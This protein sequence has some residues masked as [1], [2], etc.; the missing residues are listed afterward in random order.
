[1]LSPQQIKKLYAKALAA[2][3]AG[4]LSDAEKSYAKILK[5]RPNVAEVQ[6]NMGRLRTQQGRL[7]EAAAHFE[8]A[9]KL[10]PGQAEIWLAYLKMAA[11][12]PNPQNLGK[13]L[14]RVGSAL[15]QFAEISFYRGLVAAGQGED[16]AALAAFEDAE[17]R[18]LQSAHLQ[19][20]LGRLHAGQGRV[21]EGLTAY[22]AA[23][24][25]EP[26]ND[27]ALAQKADLLRNIGEYDAALDAARAAIEVAP[28]AGQLYYSYA[29]IKK[30]SVGDPMIER[31]DTLMRSLSSRDPGG[32][33]LGH[34]LAKAMEDTGQADRVWSYLQKANAAQAQR[35]PY[36]LKAD[37]AQAGLYQ[38][39]FSEL[40]PTAHGS[41]GTPTPLFVTGLPR[42]GTTLVEQILASHSQCEGAG[43]IALLGRAW[44]SVLTESGLTD[45]ALSEGATDYRA[46]LA[47]RF[48]GAAYVTDK[49]I[50]SYTLIGFIRA[51]MPDAR[52]I[53]VRRDPGD[54][55]LSIYKNLFP[56]GSHR[57]AADLKTIA[58]FMRLFEAQLA[59]W[60][61]AAPD[62]FFEIRYEDLI[63]EP[64]AQSRALVDAAGL[65][66]EDACL[67]FYDSA[68]KVDTL[69]TTQV[70]Q[71][72]YSSSVGAW[73]RYADEMKP[74]FEEYEALPNDN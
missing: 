59:F 5:S 57:Y 50:S 28:K 19:I 60:K 40:G 47:S 3:D 53:V 18:G 29:S 58:R 43:E 54:N 45:Q 39:L 2:Q 42:S 22:D 67:S 16:E 73:K 25:L 65:P 62:S 69:S 31:M 66:W 46:G 48:P 10:K 23:L 64:E 7:Q 68:R 6:F 9:L 33:P 8:A 74:F 61:E 70:R 15:D 38:K 72:I 37:Q 35:Y 1:M 30:L 14:G 24:A 36:D 71:P 32:A 34:A 20:A 11:G 55:A 52:I 41:S 13:L 17:K 56:G 4:R 12:H 44:R 51:A 27:V 21:D 49:S 63:A 26:H